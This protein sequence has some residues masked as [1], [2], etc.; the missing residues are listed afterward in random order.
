MV[1][2]VY[3]KQEIDRAAGIIDSLKKTVAESPSELPSKAM[4][5]ATGLASKAADLL[6]LIREAQNK[7]DA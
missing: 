3:V 6:A 1:N 5:L 4:T 7:E 2:A